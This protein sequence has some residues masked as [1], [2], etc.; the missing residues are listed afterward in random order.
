[1]SKIIAIANQKGGVGKTTTCMNMATFAALMGKKVLAVD[2]DPQGNCSTGLGI[3]KNTLKASVYT[4]LSGDTSPKTAI[5]PT[6]VPNLDILPSNIDLAGAEVELV[7]VDDREK[8]LKGV[9]NSLRNDYDYIFIDCPPSLGL[10]TVN[11][12]A[13]ADSI[14]I[15][16]QGEFFAL[17][18]LSQL[19]NTIKLAKKFLNPSLSIEGVVLTMYDGRSKLV[20]SVAEEIQKFFGNKVYSTKIPRNVRLGE[21]PSYGIP[22][23]Y[24]EPRSLGSIAYKSLT[25]EFFIRNKVKYEKIADMSKLKAK[26]K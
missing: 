5:I 9:L 3:E 21:A 1:M 26:V 23:A 7:S 22:I 14:L 6:I 13:S 18:G 12:L 4:V 8:V 25:E 11:A 16:I 20:Q 2:I 15:P 19:L 24:Y 17:E 10:L